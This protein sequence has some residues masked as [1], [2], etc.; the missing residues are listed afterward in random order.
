M[1]KLGLILKYQK[2]KV[3]ALFKDQSTVRTQTCH[4][5][6]NINQVFISSTKAIQSH[7]YH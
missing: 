7:T 4:I 5:Y 6:I 1:I 2:E 3:R